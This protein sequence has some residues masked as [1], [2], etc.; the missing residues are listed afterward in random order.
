MEIEPATTDCSAE[1]LQLSHQFI[2]HIIDAKLA[3]HGNCTGNKG[4]EIYPWV[5]IRENVWI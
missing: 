2:S 3:S 1:T 5:N 4:F